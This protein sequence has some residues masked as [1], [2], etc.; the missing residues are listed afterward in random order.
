MGNSNNNRI[1]N[2]VLS[3]NTTAQLA[4]VG[5][6]SIVRLNTGWVTEAHGNA[7][8]TSGNTTAVV[9]HGLSMTPTLEQISVTPQTSLGSA[10]FYWISTVTSTQFTINLNANPAATVTFGWKADCGY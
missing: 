8:I 9:T 6:A 10:A 7:S 3:G 5:A 1:Q 2:N 4:T